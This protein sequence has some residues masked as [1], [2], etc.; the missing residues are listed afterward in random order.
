MLAAVGLSYFVADAAAGHHHRHVALLRPLPVA[1]MTLGVATFVGRRG[2]GAHRRRGG[3]GYFRRCRR[4][5]WSS[6]VTKLALGS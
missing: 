6:T 5:R 1:K 2:D 3:Y 4:R